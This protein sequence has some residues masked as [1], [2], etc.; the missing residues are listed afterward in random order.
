MKQTIVS[1]LGLSLALSSFAFA[2][3]TASLFD[4]AAYTSQGITSACGDYNGRTASAG[5]IELHDF[6][7]RGGTSS[8]CA[9]SGDAQV[10]TFR[11]AV[12]DANSQPGCVSAKHYDPEF[13]LFS[14]QTR[15]KLD[16]SALNSA[17]FNSSA[18]YH[19]APESATIARLE[20]DEGTFQPGRIIHLKAAAGQTLVVD[21]AGPWINFVHMGIDLAPGL[22]A[23]HIVW[24]FFEAKY[25]GIALSGMNDLG[26]PG[27]VIAPLATVRFQNARITGALYA[28]KIIGQAD[29]APECTGSNAGQINAAPFA[30]ERL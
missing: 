4:F 9:L 12:Q 16:Y 3:E 19:S 5:P 13:T 2:K 15:S 23:D 21:V 6:L 26:V 28:A 11:G 24:N 8:A 20:L 27:T 14:N 17:L 1:V 18:A 10:T 22:T 25:L 30:G 29:D 7:I